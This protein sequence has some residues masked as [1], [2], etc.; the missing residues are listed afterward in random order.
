MHF[1]STLRGRFVGDLSL[2]TE[3]G[4][5]VRTALETAETKDLEGESRR[6]P[7]ERRADAMV[8]ICKEFLDHHNRPTTPCNRTHVTVIVGLE[9]AESYRSGRYLDGFPTD[10]VEL[11]AMLCDSKLRRLIMAAGSQVLDLGKPTKV[12]PDGLRDAVIVRDQH[13]GFG[14]CDRGPRWCD[15]H[16]VVWVTFDGITVITNLVLLCGRHH[17]LLHRPG[18]N[19]K[20]LPD[21]TFEVTSPDGLTRTS[22]PPGATPAL[23]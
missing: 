14:Q 3:G 6:T 1:S 9:D 8:D 19:A 2:D 23:L 17:S 13:C 22:R 10:K 18:W 12:V 21:G 5:L 11:S 20:L 4:E 7:A 16:H 15:V